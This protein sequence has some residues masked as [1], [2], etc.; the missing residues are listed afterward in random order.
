[1]PAYRKEIIKDNY[2]QE[3]NPQ[4]S[5]FTVFE[6]VGEERLIW[7]FWRRI[8]KSGSEKDV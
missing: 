2:V 8:P 7:I 6:Y 3:L 5:S 1:M 4:L